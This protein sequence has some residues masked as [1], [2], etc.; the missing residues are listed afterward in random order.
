MPLW[1]DQTPSLYSLAPPRV[2]GLEG[3][4]QAGDGVVIY[5]D[6]SAAQWHG[7]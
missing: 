4:A 2:D 5:A 3:T 7:K 6:R 1:L